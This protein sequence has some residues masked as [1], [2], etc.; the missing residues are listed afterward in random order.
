MEGLAPLRPTLA[1]HSPPRSA[2]GQVSCSAGE[3]G[4][5]KPWYANR[6]LGDFKK[7]LISRLLPGDVLL[8]LGDERIGIFFHLGQCA[9]PVVGDR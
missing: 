1:L 2:N 5:A 9:Q 6:G 8:D 4:G 3:G 7:F